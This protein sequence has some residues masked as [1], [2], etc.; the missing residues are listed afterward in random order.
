MGLLLPFLVGAAYGAAISLLG[1]WI[2]G[3]RGQLA[4]EVL[5]LMWAIITWKL[6][7]VLYE[8]FK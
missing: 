1:R 7:K 2:G 5:L 8:R 3:V 4:A 6:R